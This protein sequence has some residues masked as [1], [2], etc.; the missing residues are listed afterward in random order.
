MADIDLDA[1]RARH[2]RDERFGQPVIP[3]CREC[4][5]E[6]PCDALRLLAALDGEGEPHS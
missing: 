5:Q 4:G 6:L 2:V 3:W 1:I